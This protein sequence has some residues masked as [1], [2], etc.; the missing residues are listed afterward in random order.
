MYSLGSFPLLCQVAVI[1]HK[2]RLVLKGISVKRE[3]FFLGT[4]VC[5]VSYPRYLAQRLFWLY[6]M[7][8]VTLI[9][10]CL[11]RINY[12]NK[13]TPNKRFLQRH[14]P[15]ATTLSGCRTVD[16]VLVREMQLR[17]S[18]ILQY[19]SI[20]IIVHICDYCLLFILSIKLHKITFF[21]VQSH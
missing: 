18:Q 14:H 13:N 1:V 5:R 10:N 8:Q 11:A 2:N 20:G 17:Q 12:I 21:Y 15:P 3:G 6:Q 19:S 9:R 7:L 16:R 4:V